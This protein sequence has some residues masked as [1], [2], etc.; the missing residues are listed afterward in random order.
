[1][2]ISIAEAALGARVNVPTL[3]GSV[4]LSIPAGTS[5][6]Q[7]LRLKGLGLKDEAGG[8]GDLFAV[9][10]VIAPKSLEPDERAALEKMGKRLPTIREGPLW[11]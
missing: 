11:G 9:A 8:V 10:K 4:E 7:R 1:L 3:T 2:P 5:S 6:G